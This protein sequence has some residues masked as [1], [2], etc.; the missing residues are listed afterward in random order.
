MKR[1]TA[2][3]W[4]EKCFYF[5]SFRSIGLTSLFHKYFQI[6]FL[7]HQQVVTMQSTGGEGKGF[8]VCFLGNKNETSRLPSNVSHA[9]ISA[10]LVVR[11]QQAW[12]ARNVV[13]LRGTENIYQNAVFASSHVCSESWTGCEGVTPHRFYSRQTRT[14]SRART[15]QQVQC[16]LFSAQN[17]ESVTHWPA[18]YVTNGSSL[19]SDK[20][21]SEAKKSRVAVRRGTHG[22]HRVIAC[23]ETA[24]LISLHS[25]SEAVKVFRITG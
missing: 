16:T 1:R 5:P 4:G 12:F 6:A 21:I 11:Q 18:A 10:S 14:D 7:L 24:L 19:C 23:R 13:R 20:V 15:S 2:T 8:S 25:V 3:A 17:Q 9:N 22:T